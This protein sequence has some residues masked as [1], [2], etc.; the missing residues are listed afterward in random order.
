MTGSRNDIIHSTINDIGRE[1]FPENTDVSWK[2][3]K[4]VHVGA[5]SFVEAEAHPATVGYPKF[6]F[7]LEFEKWDKPSVVGCYEGDGNRWGLLF[8]AETQSGWQHVFPESQLTERGGRF[9]NRERDQVIRE[10]MNDIGRKSFPE[11]TGVSW[12]VLKIVHAGEYSFV[13]SEPDSPDVGYPK[14]IFVL[15]FTE[16][17]KP[18]QVACYCFDRKRWSLLCTAEGAS[19]DWQELFP[20]RE[21]AEGPKGD[22][23]AGV[24]LAAFLSVAI[25]VYLC[26]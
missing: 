1:A 7:V 5:Y 12:A 16:S 17:G 18:F 25:I 20:E 6:V 19:S 2:V 26:Q 24:I 4:V 9:G 15:Q 21:F 8:G 13:E 23:C 11:D 14:F 3:L 22:G 10:R